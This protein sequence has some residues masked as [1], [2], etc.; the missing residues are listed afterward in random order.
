MFQVCFLRISLRRKLAGKG[1][2]APESKMENSRLSETDPIGTKILYNAC[3][4]R[5]PNIS[6]NMLW[7]S[8]AN[9]L[10]ASA[11]SD[12]LNQVMIS[13]AVEEFSA[14]YAE[15]IKLPVP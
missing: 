11:G 15:R 3:S 13:F 8:S 6:G 9:T 5:F 7:S 2:K 1:L 12:A 10:K 14:T 4:P